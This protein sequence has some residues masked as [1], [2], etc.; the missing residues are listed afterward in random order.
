MTTELNMSEQVTRHAFQEAIAPLATR[1]EFEIWNGA[2]IG[3]MDAQF[4]TLQLHIDALQRD[5]E[6]MWRELRGNMRREIDA[7]RSELQIDLARH[8][9]VMP[10]PTRST[11]LAMDGGAADPSAQTDTLDRPTT[12]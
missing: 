1:R 6:A 7:M 10:E 2:L 11:I 8:D 9:H 12:T 3:R 4:E 5:M